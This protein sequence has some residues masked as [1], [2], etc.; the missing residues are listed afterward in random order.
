MII[1]FFRDAMTDEKTIR[2][3]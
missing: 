2:R 1:D 3:I